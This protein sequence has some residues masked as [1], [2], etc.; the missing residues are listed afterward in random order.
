MPRFNPSTI[1]KIYN[2]YTM[3]KNICTYIIFSSSEETNP[4]LS[5]KLAEN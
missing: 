4:Q 5:M 1:K 3:Y 2:I